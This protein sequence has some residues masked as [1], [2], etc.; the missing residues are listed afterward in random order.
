MMDWSW[1]QD[2]FQKGEE[3]TASILSALQRLLT[4]CISQD[5]EVV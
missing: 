5:G 4:G 3:V 1:V 2:A